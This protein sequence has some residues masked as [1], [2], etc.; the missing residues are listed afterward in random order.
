MNNTIRNEQNTKLKTDITHKQ[1]TNK[2]RTKQKQNTF[3]TQTEYK[4]NTI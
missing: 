1:H 2:R 4:Q 3:K